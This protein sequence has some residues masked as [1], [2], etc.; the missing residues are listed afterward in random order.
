M[1]KP[2]MFGCFGGCLK[3]DMHNHFRVG[4]LVV[5]PDTFM[6]ACIC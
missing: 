4:E 3:R 2:R 1:P 6:Y 5:D